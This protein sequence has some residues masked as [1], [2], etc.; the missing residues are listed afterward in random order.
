MDDLF[1]IILFLGIV[2]FVFYLIFKALKGARRL[3][4][5]EVLAEIKLVQEQVKT[6]NKQLSET[7]TKIDDLDWK[8]VRT[9][10]QAVTEIK[11]R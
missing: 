5:S 7:K 3:V 1:V 4:M 10:D 8:M 6:A 2:F 11:K 9:I